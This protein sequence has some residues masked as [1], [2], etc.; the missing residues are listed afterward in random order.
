MMLNYITLGTGPRRVFALHGWLGDE[1]C[2]KPMATAL[3][4]SDFTY[5]FPA[6]R[7]YG[8]SKGLRGEYSMAEIAADVLALADQLDWSRFSLI[9]HSMGGMAV[10]RVLADAPER[11]E[12][13]VAITPV[14][15]NGVPFDDETRSFFES[16]AESMQTRRAILDR[17]SGSRLSGAWLDHMA[18]ASKQS[19]IPEAVA[20]YFKAWSTTNFVEEIQENTTLVKVIVGEHD[21]DLN[22]DVMTATY[23]AW[24]PNAELEVMANAGHYPMD[25]TPVALATSVER[26]LRNT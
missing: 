7:G 8:A 22:T 10:Q 26:F 17:S 14:P 6:Y 19:S 24:Y 13:L 21:R 18:A 20:G 15:A 9:G 23:L 12:R 1:T 16:A 5:V 4:P 25:E 3:T 11:V 2:F